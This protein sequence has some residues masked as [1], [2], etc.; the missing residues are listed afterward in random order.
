MFPDQPVA[1][2]PLPVNYAIG[3]EGEVRQS[4]KVIFMPE[5]GTLSQLPGC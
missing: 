1:A 3:L 4:S 5:C 2:R